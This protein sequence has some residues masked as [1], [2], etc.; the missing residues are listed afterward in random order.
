MIS[1][2]IYNILNYII[3]GIAL[4]C[5]ALIT[6]ANFFWDD[7]YVIPQ[8]EVDARAI[9]APKSFSEILG[10]IFI[11]L[12]L[13]LLKKPLEKIR[14]QYVFWICTGIYFSLGLYLVI[15]SNVAL[16]AD[17][18]L[19]WLSVT[20]MLEHDYSTIT[21]G[22][23]VAIYTNQLGFLFFE[24]ILANFTVDVRFWYGVF[25][26]LSVITN[27]L[28]WQ[29][30]RL[31][32]NKPM[33][34]KY[35]AIV[36]TMFFPSIFF[37]LFM[38][39]NLLGFCMLQFAV[40]FLLRY[41]KN[42]DYVD[43]IAMALFVGLACFFKNNYL[44]GMIAVA[45]LLVVDIFKSQKLRNILATILVVLSFFVIQN[46]AQ[47]FCE[48]TVNADFSEYMPY[49]NYIYIGLNDDKQ[50]M[51]GWFTDYGLKLAMEHEDMHQ[52]EEILRNDVKARNSY[53]FENKEYAFDFFKR[54]IHFTWCNQNFDSVYSGPYVTENCPMMTRI[55]DSIYFM[56]KGFY[57]IYK[58]NGMINLI[59]YVGTLGFIVIKLF[60]K[61]EPIDGAIL[62]PLLWLVG[63]FLFHLVWEVKS[64]YVLYYVFFLVPY[65][66]YTLDYI[67]EL[68]NQ[69]FDKFR[70]SRFGTK[71]EEAN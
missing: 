44:I 50:G 23:Y 39:G 65:A 53:L 24:Y 51:P 46:S 14:E 58:F 4:L 28:M 35:A 60:V 22:G 31:M 42:Y 29:N 11:A 26:I 13:I 17:A 71:T 48:M 55:L 62:Y 52:V 68:V 25:L 12:V 30:V 56:D 41:L 18:A 5:T 21:S 69:K 15:N 54:K 3:V 43:M 49:V 59:L 16:K 6:Y 27:F 33:I 45:V 8:I 1:N 47:L 70:Q 63:G 10:F 9:Y 66:G 38:Y 7:V 37:I 32:F 19:M 67:S 57:C 34:G 61:K 2:R 20:R 36:M 64:Q 40:F